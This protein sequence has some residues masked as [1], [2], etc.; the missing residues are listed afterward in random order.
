MRRRV[1]GQGGAKAPFLSFA[2]RM[3]EWALVLIWVVIN[4]ASGAV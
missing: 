3:T 2:L 4:G 1:N